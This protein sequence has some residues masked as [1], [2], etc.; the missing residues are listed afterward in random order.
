MPNK[1]SSS[2]PNLD[3]SKTDFGATNVQIIEAAEEVAEEVAEEL[4][5]QPVEEDVVEHVMVTQGSLAPIA[6]HGH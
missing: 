1:S 2:P 3:V 6:I 4:V 5:A